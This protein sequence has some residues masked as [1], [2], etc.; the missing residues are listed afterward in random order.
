[1]ILHR[2]ILNR[3]VSCLMDLPAILHMRDILVVAQAHP[4]ML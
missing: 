4:H 1:M 2:Q 3:L